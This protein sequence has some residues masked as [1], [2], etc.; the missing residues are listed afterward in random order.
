MTTI[1]QAQLRFLIIVYDA[2]PA[3]AGFL[4][5]CA[6]GGKPQNLARPASNN[7][8]RLRQQWLVSLES[9]KDGNY[10]SITEKGRRTILLEHNYQKWHDDPD[11]DDPGLFDDDADYCTCPVCL[12]LRAA[13]TKAL[14][15]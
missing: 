15:P 14:K 9:R 1:T 13:G 3:K 5:A 10:W 8:H 4:G 6:Y 2:G 11:D 12:R 7:L